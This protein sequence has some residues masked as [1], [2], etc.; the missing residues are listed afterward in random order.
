MPTLSID[1]IRG[2]VLHSRNVYKDFDNEEFP[3]II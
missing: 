1:K 2:N 3:A